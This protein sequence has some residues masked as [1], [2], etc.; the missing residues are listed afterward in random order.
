MSPAVPRLVFDL[1]HSTFPFCCTWPNRHKENVIIGAGSR[2]T[3]ETKQTSCA[4]PEHNPNP[5]L[6][7]AGEEGTEGAA[8]PPCL[9]GAGARTAG[10]WLRAAQSSTG[11][12]LEKGAE[13]GEMSWRSMSHLPESSSRASLHPVS[14]ASF[15]ETHHLQVLPGGLGCAGSTTWGCTVTQGDSPRTL[16]EAL[17]L[18][19]LLSVFLQCLGQESRLPEGLFALLCLT[20][21]L[22]PALVLRLSAGPGMVVPVNLSCW[23]SQLTSGCSLVLLSTANTSSLPV[24]SAEQNGARDKEGVIKALIM[25]LSPF[26]SWL[27][28]AELCSPAQLC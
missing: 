1:S 4:L 11:T 7:Q 22:V 5:L 14:G 19:W 9:A 18:F 12:T 15:S 27:S 23:E 25:E 2:I 16:E 3:K 13:P 26:S 17:V 24:L 21:A 6:L 10:S 20:K 8:S 28:Q